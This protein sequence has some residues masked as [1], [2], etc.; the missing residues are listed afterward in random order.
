MPEPELI[1]LPNDNIMEDG[2]AFLADIE[3]TGAEIV[4]WDAASGKPMLVR[5]KVGKGYV[6]T[7]T[8]WAY[9]G[10]EQFQ[11]FS[12]SWVSKLAEENKLDIYINDSSNEV[13]WTVWENENE[14]TVYI[15]NTDWVEKGNTKLVTLVH[16]G[17][18]E[19]L[20]IKERCLTVVR[21]TENSINTEEYSIS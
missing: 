2:K 18:E 8:V 20:S 17:K 6:Y 9:A 15:L 5:N 7:F 21:L 14:K 1:S 10:H 19:M 4:A 11:T 3:L 12:A 13:F 16:N